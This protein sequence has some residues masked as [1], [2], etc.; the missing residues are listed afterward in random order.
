MLWVVGMRGKMAM[1]GVVGGRRSAL[2][3][4]LCT[5]NPHYLHA[6]LL[7]LLLPGRL[8]GCCSQQ[9]C[10][11]SITQPCSAECSWRGELQL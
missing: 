1:G 5:H 10:H 11:V 8:P 3:L 9:I 4:L 7:E 2:G 6:R